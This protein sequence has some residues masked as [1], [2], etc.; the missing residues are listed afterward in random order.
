[1]AIEAV[2]LVYAPQVSIIFAIDP[3]K[4]DEETFIVDSMKSISL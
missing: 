2:G 1:M 3:E 4:P